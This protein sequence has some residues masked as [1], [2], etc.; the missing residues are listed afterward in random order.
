MRKDFY[1]DSSGTGKIHACIWHPEGEVRAVFQI[2]HGIGEHVLRYDRFAS[3]MAEKG[4]AVVA[5]DHMGHGSSIN[6]DGVKGYFHGGWFAAVADSVKLMELAKAQFPCLPYILFG[7]SMGS[8]M[9]RTI[10]AKYPEL[11]LAGCII[12]GTGWQP[13]ALLS[14]AIPLCKTVCKTS[15]EKNPSKLLHKL[16]FGNYN[17]RVEHLRTPSD[18]LTR[19][20]KIV[21]AYQ[22]D[23]LCGFIPTAGLSRDML[24]GI[25]HIQQK[26]SLDNMNKSL[27]CFFV[28]GGDD[29]VGDYGKSVMQTVEAFRKSGM[30][31]VSF[32]LYPLA[33][34]E[35]LN[36][37]NWEEIYADILK[38]VENQI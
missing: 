32:K 11:E 14:I 12:C 22:T 3:W 31:Q 26:D 23:P 21:D 38:W 36:E 18:W 7:H 30:E 15:G 13:K 10:L 27:P 34:H 33:R 8:F 24:M 37:L 9:V 4:I 28:A 1:F 35:I 29:P 2:V 25:S 17:K 5:E 20:T 16:M 19:D 6:E